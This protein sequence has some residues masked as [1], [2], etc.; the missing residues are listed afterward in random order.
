M[1]GNLLTEHTR[2]QPLRG[3]IGPERRGEKRRERRKRG[4]LPFYPIHSVLF[5]F[6]LFYN[7]GVFK[8]FNG[9]SDV[10][11]FSLQKDHLPKIWG[12]V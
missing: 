12:T 4:T 11:I 1:S 6:A 7:T 2:N 9:G 10:T 8:E 5:A 3:W